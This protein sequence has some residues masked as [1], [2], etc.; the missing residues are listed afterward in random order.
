MVMLII[1]L[2]VSYGLRRKAIS[3]LNLTF[4]YFFLT[5]PKIAKKTEG[6]IS[7][8]QM[9]ADLHKKIVLFTHLK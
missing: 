1:Q 4:L 6:I 3:T 9:E 8:W 2:F 5:F 7:L